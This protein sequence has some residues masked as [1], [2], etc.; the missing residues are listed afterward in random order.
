MTQPLAGKRHTLAVTLSGMSLLDRHT[1][2]EALAA[3]NARLAVRGCRAEL[4]LVGGA[5]MCLVHDARPATRDVDG[6]FTEPEAV[7]TAA[8]EVAQD[9]SLPDDWLN[10]AAKGFVPANAGYETWASL[11]NLT[12]A[13]VDARTLLAMKAAAA[14]TVEDVDDIRFLAERLGLRSADA[15][16]AVVLAYFSADRLPVRVRLPLEEMFDERA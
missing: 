6:W 15:V 9:F 16:L 1:I 8:R 13:T 10:D 3:L 4:F 5:V 7:R 11:S 14:R 2:I 12:V